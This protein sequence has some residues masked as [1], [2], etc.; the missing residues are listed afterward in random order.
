MSLKP[1]GPQQTN[2]KSDLF[3][4]FCS[5]TT[6]SKQNQIQLFSLGVFHSLSFNIYLI[7]FFWLSEM[8]CLWNQLKSLIT[9]WV[10][11]LKTDIRAAHPSIS[12]VYTLIHSE[13]FHKK[14][15]IKWPRKKELR[16]IWEG[17]TNMHPQGASR[18]DK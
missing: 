11:S 1:L 17:E 16:G 5:V 9:H 13:G 15:G 7:F 2:I 4:P 18:S 6:N 10:R 3:A 12:T 8:S 14:A